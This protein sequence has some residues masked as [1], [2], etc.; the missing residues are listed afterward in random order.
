MY[1]KEIRYCQ[2]SFSASNNKFINNNHINALFDLGCLIIITTTI[3]L[4]KSR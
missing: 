1:T 3:L 2:V 4:Q